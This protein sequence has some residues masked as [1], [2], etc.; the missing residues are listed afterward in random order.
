MIGQILL[1]NLNASFNPNQYLY[2]FSWVWICNAPWY[3]K[4][5]IQEVTIPLPIPVCWV[6]DADYDLD[7]RNDV[8]NV[9]GTGVFWFHECF[10]FLEVKPVVVFPKNRC[11]CFSCK[12]K[13]TFKTKGHLFFDIDCFWQKYFVVRNLTKLLGKFHSC[14]R[15]IHVYMIMLTIII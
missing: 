8:P 15:Y 6:S 4:E 12:K 14:W 10:V 3:E 7:I 11:T 13:K 5:I 2:T 1:L 9:I